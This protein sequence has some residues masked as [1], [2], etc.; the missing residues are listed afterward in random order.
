MSWWRTDYLW[1][2][3]NGQCRDGVEGSTLWFMWGESGV[4]EGPRLG[5]PYGNP[6]VTMFANAN[7]K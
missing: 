7:A 3:T 4:L 5:W 6:I 1:G 2:M